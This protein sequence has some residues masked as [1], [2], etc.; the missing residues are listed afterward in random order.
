MTRY[1]VT[2][3]LDATGEPARTASMEYVNSGSKKDGLAHF[4]AMDD[5]IDRLFVAGLKMGIPFTIRITVDPI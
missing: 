3:Y 4:Y 2:I 1:K 5:A